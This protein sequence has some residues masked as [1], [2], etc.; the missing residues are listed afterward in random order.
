[1]TYIVAAV[2]VW[3][4]PI[5]SYD[6]ITGYSLTWT[7]LLWPADCV[8]HAE[9]RSALSVLRKYRSANETVWVWN[10]PIF[11]RAGGVCAMLLNATEGSCLTTVSWNFMGSK[12]TCGFWSWTAARRVA[13]VF[14]VCPFVRV[15]VCAFDLRPHVRLQKKRITAQHGHGVCPYPTHQAV[16]ERVQQPAEQQA[17]SDYHI[18]HHCPRKHTGVTLLADIQTL[19]STLGCSHPFPARCNIVIEPERRLWTFTQQ[20]SHFVLL[21]TP[22]VQFSCSHVWHKKKKAS[23]AGSGVKKRK[24][25][26][27]CEKVR[28]RKLEKKN[29]DRSRSIGKG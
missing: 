19:A 16:C 17:L 3:I 6:N 21:F 27:W 29:G 5:L 25:D 4:K 9:R 11:L 7:C 12:V 10:S 18:Y 23:L 22:A 1:M 8:T 14:C 24:R 2:N 15:H 26:G 20:H 28:M 13:C